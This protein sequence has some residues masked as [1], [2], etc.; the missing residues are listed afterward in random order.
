MTEPHLHQDCLE[1][2]VGI[3]IFGSLGLP[4]SG[5]R[6]LHDILG[7]CDYFWTVTRIASTR[8][9]DLLLGYFSRRLFF[10]S[11]H[12]SLVQMQPVVEISRGVKRIVLDSAPYFSRSGF[13]V[14]FEN[15]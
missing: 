5:C 3:T 10:Q 9:F 15:T 11:S 2:A 1:L 7:F 13:S 6:I 12:D 4:R 14:F 8:L